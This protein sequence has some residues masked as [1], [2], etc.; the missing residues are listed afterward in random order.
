MTQLITL[1]HCSDIGASSAAVRSMSASEP[2]CRHIDTIRAPISKDWHYCDTIVRNRCDICAALSLRARRVPSPFLYISPGQWSTRIAKLAKER[3][4]KRKEGK[5]GTDQEHALLA[6]CHTYYVNGRVYPQRFL[7]SVQTE[8]HI[9]VD[10]RVR[11]RM[12]VIHAR[13]VERK[14]A[15]LCGHLR[16][17]D[18]INNDNNN[19]TIMTTTVATQQQQ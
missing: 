10:A 5:E 16:W 18:S 15:E 6:H 7:Q 1:L 9:R 12:S 4:K 2:R 19:D 3:K 8:A 17:F 11:P 14:F 13:R